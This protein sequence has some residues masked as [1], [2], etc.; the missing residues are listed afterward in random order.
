MN[1]MD[2]F[3]MDMKYVFCKFCDE[4][5]ANIPNIMMHKKMKHRETRQEVLVSQHKKQ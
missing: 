2:T 5:F 4:K 1:W 3:G